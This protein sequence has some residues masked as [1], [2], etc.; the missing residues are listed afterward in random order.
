ME[1]YFDSGCLRPRA[2][3]GSVHASPLTRVQ[4]VLSLSRRLYA[5]AISHLKVAMSLFRSVGGTSGRYIDRFQSS[6]PLLPSRT[7][8]LRPTPRDE[9]PDIERRASL[10]IEEDEPSPATVSVA[11]LDTTPS[12]ASS[13]AL[14]ASAPD[15]LPTP[16]TLK[17]EQTGQQVGNVITS[18][19]RPDTI[20]RR[21][22]TTTVTSITTRQAAL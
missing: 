10:G 13:P 6:S 14:P 18:S 16:L 21:S 15:L 3:S 8:S 4:V 1:I 2:L 11:M 20:A 17:F 7:G 12:R 9:P 22:S 5:H 19:Y